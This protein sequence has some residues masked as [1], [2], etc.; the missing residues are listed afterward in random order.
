MNKEDWGRV[1]P[2]VE[3]VAKQAAS[4]WRG[5]V[6]ADDVHQTLCQFILERPSVQKMIQQKR[7]SDVSRLLRGY[8]NSVCKQEQLDYEH[9]TG[10]FRYIPKQV[11]AIIEGHY[12]PEEKID[13]DIGLET[14]KE[15]FPRAY[16][17]LTECQLRGTHAEEVRFYRAVDTL[18]DCMNSCFSNRVFQR[19]DGPGTKPSERKKPSIPVESWDQFKQGV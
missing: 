13:L 18:T 5:L 16:D 15:L 14:L 10:N 3:R 8:A 2:L 4:S 19:V 6:D 1:L 11:R 12:S 9:F 7:K 17:A